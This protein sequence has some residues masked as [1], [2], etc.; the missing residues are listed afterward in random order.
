MTPRPA[1]HARGVS[2]IVVLVI[3][4]I[5]SILGVSAAHLSMMT[6]RGARNDRDM[7]MAWQAA[8]AALMDAE[9]DLTSPA[10]NGRAVAFEN[11]DFSL[12]VEQGCG[13]TGPGK[14]L[15]D[16]RQVGGRP[17]WLSIDLA[18]QD[19]PAT[20]YGEFTGSEFASGPQGLRPAGK[21]RY[22]IEALPDRT[23]DA[24]GPARRFVYRV[25][26]LGFGP[27]EDIQAVVQMLFR[28]D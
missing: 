20:Q 15:C 11:H 13:A 23:G 12:F 24:S 27:R 10:R 28:R 26:A 6:E 3:L 16:A 25:T 19:A 22:L 18:A 8:E 5:T 17:L 9:L 1:P 7:Q 2:L 4:A 21:P 14:G